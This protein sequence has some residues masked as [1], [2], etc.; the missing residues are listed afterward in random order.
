MRA[1][2]AVYE[3]QTKKLRIPKD[4][5]TITVVRTK[6]KSDEAWDKVNEAQALV[7]MAW[8]LVSEA[9]DECG[10]VLEDLPVLPPIGKT[11]EER[12]EHVELEKET[13]ETAVSDLQSLEDALDGIDFSPA[14]ISAPS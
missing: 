6:A 8:Q 1:I 10:Y 11:E 2:Q 4:G 7:Q 12:K 14:L 3:V 13:W 9:K 5:E